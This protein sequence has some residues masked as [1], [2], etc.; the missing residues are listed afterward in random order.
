[1]RYLQRDCLVTSDEVLAVFAQRAEA[2]SGASDADSGVADTGAIEL[3][4]PAAAEV[5]V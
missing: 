5:A 3:G 1:M 4:R 2:D